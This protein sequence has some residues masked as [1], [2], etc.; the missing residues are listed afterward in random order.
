MSF[1]TSVGTGICGHID[2]DG[3]P[4]FFQLNCGGLYFGGAGVG[5][6]LPSIVPDLGTS[7]TKAS[8][9]G[10]TVTLTGTSPTEAGGNRCAGGTNHHN[11]CTVDSD[12]PGGRC[13]FLQCS[14]AGCLFGPPLP[15][16]NSS[17]GGA[18]TSSCT[19]NVAAAN[20]TGTAD[21]LTGSTS[22]LSLPLSSQLFLDQDLMPMR[23][24][25]GTNPG[26]NCTG[27]GGCGTVAPG[28]PCPGTGGTCVNDTARCTAPDPANTVCCSDG[29][30]TLGTCETGNCAGGS[31]ANHGCITDADCPGGGACKTFIQ[32]CPI[33]NATTGKCQG[34][35]NDGLVCTPGN[36][37]LNG[38][39]PTS[40]DCPPPPSLQIGALPISFVLDTGT[41]SKTAL[42]KPSQVNV[43]CAFCRNKTTNQSG[44]RCNG[45][46]T[47]AVCTCNPGLPCN[48]CGGGP[49]LPVPCT[50]DADCASVTGFLNCQQRTSGAFTSGDVARTI[51]ETGSPAGPLTTGGAAKP[52]TLV[53]IFCIPPSFNSLVDSAADLPGPGA[54]SL[55]GTTQ[56]MP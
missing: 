40:H 33:C 42:N 18:A 44:R 23:C 6:P 11:S 51:V 5:V 7:I 2:A 9:S 50:T 56:A 39:Y 14:N 16:P 35:P 47:G 12:C 10:T 27:S 26:A 43:F 8:C 22:A 53:S 29:D 49:C 15:I 30:C 13:K 28:T 55:P 3:N 37:A 34:G 36:S 25:G 20:A 1:T 31:S 52:A 48:A 4:N 46:A 45:S 17:H 21:C 41:I 24:K 32:S 54:V 38:D 19:I